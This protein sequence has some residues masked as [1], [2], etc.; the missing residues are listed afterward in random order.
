[1]EKQMLEVD[2][3][4]YSQQVDKLLSKE[5]ALSQT[6]KLS[7]KPLRAA[8]V[9][10]QWSGF[11]ELNTAQE[12]A[13][14]PEQFVLKCNHDTHSVVIVKDKEELLA[15][16]AR[17][18]Q[19]EEKFTKALATSPYRIDRERYYK[20][21]KPRIFAEEFIDG[22][23]VDYRV[24]CIKGEPQLVWMDLDVLSNH[25]RRNFYSPDG[26]FP[27]DTTMHFPNNPN[28]SHPPAEFFE[29]LSTFSKQLAKDIPVVRTDFFE[30]G[31]E[32]YFSEMTF[33][34]NNNSNPFNPA[35]LR[36]DF[37]KLALS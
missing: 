6:A 31:G 22:D 23:L 37:A 5:W 36:T 33:S 19:M 25:R 15:D 29:R 27:S 4:E 2:P 32:I 9:L 26:K 10:G 11:A 20:N 21:V 28:V 16:T 1:M 34:S 7:G 8:K 35:H 18:R 12:W 30:A 13:N 17:V 3:D 14:L 24:L